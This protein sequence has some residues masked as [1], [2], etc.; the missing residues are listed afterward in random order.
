MRRCNAL[1]T[2]ADHIYSWPPA[3]ADWEFR[4]LSVS[5]VFDI[6]HTWC[7]FCREVVLASCAG[8]ITRTGARIPPRAGDNSWQRIGYEVQRASQRRPIA[9]AA[10]LTLRHQE[11]TWGDV[12]VLVRAI[13]TVAPGN[14]ATLT[15]GFG[16]ALSGPRHLQQ[17]RNACAHLNSAT[18]LRI[19]ALSV[20]YSAARIQHPCDLLW[21]LEPSSKSDA[22]FC[23]IEELEI[24][25]DEVTK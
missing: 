5:M 20:H 6:W 4:Y 9:A 11:P 2:K 13:P 16:L 7:D 19:R 25:A 17:V 23:W 22:V 12:S 10:R 15:T 18:V 1:R 24:M 8:T 21:S 14:Q 3:R